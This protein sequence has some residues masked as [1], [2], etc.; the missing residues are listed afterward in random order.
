[1]TVYQKRALVVC[2]S[3]PGHIRLNPRCRLA[4]L[5]F[6]G[7]YSDWRTIGTS[8]TDVRI[9]GLLTENGEQENKRLKEEWVEK[10]MNKCYTCHEAIQKKKLFPVGRGGDLLVLTG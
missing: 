3:L 10:G 2:D 8:R 1:M 6:Q 5:L 7:S 9:R 4:R